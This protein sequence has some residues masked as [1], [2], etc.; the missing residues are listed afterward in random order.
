MNNLLETKEDA[1]L[2]FLKQRELC[3]EGKGFLK[4]K[5]VAEAVVALLATAM[6]LVAAMVNWLRVKVWEWES[7]RKI[8]QM[9]QESFVLVMLINPFLFFFGIYL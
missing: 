6:A 5:Q 4:S 2:R 1:G 3:L 8:K 9:R 7:H